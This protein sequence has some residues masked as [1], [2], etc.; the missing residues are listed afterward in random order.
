MKIKYITNVRIPTSRAHGFAI[1]KMCEKFAENGAD[2]ELCVPDKQN[3]EKESDP[4]VHYGV[5]KNFQIKKIWSFDFLGGYEAFG[6]L[7][8]WIDFGSFLTSLFF[9]TRRMENEIIYTRDFLLTFFVPGSKFIV[10]ELHDLPSSKFL[11]KKALDRSEMIVVIS[12]SLK[13]EIMT[14]GVQE[15]K[16][17]IFPS[18]VDVEDFNIKETKEVLAKKLKLSDDKPLVVYTGQFYGWKGADT[19]AEAGKGV[20]EANFVFVGGVEPE[21]SRFKN[22]YG[23]LPNIIIRKS[24]PRHEIPLYMKV[25]DIL[26][27]PN[28]GKSKISTSYTSPIK[29]FEYMASGRPIIAS[30]L[31]SIRE[32]VGEEDVV[33]A[34]PDESNS[35]VFAIK[36]VLKDKKLSESIASKVL[37]KSTHFSWKERAFKILD[38]IEGLI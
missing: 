37:Q 4:F 20:P 36:K 18:G 38:I 16:I 22:K 34:I 8:Y 11:L 21:L 14:L 24:V 5:Q 6:K 13:E 32:I 10:L 1:M 29:L 27:L 15:K 12:K 26:V 28:S 9:Y 3:N 30:D 33:F 31:P 23:S 2:V 7:F 25:A 17:F 19:L 35:F